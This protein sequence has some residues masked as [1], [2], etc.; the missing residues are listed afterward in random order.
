MVFLSF[1]YNFLYKTWIKNLKSGDIMDVVKVE[2]N[3]KNWS[4]AIVNNNSLNRVSFS[5]LSDK[6][7][8]DREINKPSLDI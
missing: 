1:Q 2:E 4:R 3:L 8:F 6:K 7:S 5:F